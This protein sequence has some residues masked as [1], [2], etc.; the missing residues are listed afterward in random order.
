MLYGTGEKGSSPGRERCERLLNAAE[1]DPEPEQ[2]VALVKHKC[3][4]MSR[5]SFQI[6]YYSPT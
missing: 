3:V 5:H 1:T 4:S 6:M 2:W